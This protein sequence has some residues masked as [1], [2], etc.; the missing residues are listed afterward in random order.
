[1]AFTGTAVVTQVADNL[2]RITGLGLAGAAA[3]T[4]GLFENSGSPG[5]RLPESFRPRPYVNGIDENVSLQDSLEIT[6]VP[7]TSVTTLVP[8]K[9]VK[10]GTVPTDAL[11]TLTN[12]T[13][14]TASAE[15]EIYVRHH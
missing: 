4:I 2:M 7:V 10:T 1:M 15:V 8:I 12:T 5:V 3:G 6:M 13:V 14:G 9:A 11:I